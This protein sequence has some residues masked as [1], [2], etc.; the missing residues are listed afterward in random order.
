[1]MQQYQ[2][3][4]HNDNLFMLLIIVYHMHYSQETEESIVT[5]IE[6]IVVNAFKLV[7]NL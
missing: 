6:Y 7:E 4:I 3:F 1:M 2:I 5:K